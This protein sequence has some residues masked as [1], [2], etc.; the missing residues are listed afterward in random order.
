MPVQD[1]EG[2]DELM[3]KLLERL[4]A[5]QRQAEIRQRLQRAT[6]DEPPPH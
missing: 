4:P 1:T 3:G 5:E 2:Y 6:K